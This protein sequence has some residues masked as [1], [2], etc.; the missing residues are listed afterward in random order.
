MF[1]SLPA[2]Q[3]SGRVGQERVPQRY[4]LNRNG[5]PQHA[6]VGRH[7]V[8]PAERFGSTDCQILVPCLWTVYRRYAKRSNIAVRDEAVAPAALPDQGNRVALEGGHAHYHSWPDFHERRG[9]KDRVL[10]PTFS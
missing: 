2:E 4:E 7:H 3:A 1:P 10:H 9:G 6:L 8:A 5:A